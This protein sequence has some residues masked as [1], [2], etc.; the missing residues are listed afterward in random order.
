MQLIGFS[1]KLNAILVLFFAMCIVFYASLYLGTGII[2]E[3]ILSPFGLLALFSLICGEVFLTT[4][5]V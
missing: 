1:A 4:I 2:A 3:L 5:G